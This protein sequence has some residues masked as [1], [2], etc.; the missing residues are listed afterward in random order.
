MFSDHNLELFLLII[1]ADYFEKFSSTIKPKLLKN[2]NKRLVC[3]TTVS[4]LFIFLEMFILRF[5]VE[6]LQT[7]ISPPPLRSPSK[8]LQ[9][10]FF[11]ILK[12]FLVS[13]PLFFFITYT[14]AVQN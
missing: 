2:L 6:C 12:A 5:Y 13:L 8:K 9:K 1:F 4:K 11:W 10:K 7:E 14:S 3:L